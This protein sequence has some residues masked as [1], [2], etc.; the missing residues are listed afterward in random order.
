MLYNIKVYCFVQTLSIRNLH[1]IEWQY[2]DKDRMLTGQNRLA[3]TIK[4][5]NNKYVH[6][7]DRLEKN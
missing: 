4:Q 7:I 2:F 1:I 6:C 5:W 3:Q